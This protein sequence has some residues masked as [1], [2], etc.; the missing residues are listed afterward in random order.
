[1]QID[2]G[3]SCEGVVLGGLLVH[4]H[5]DLRVQDVTDV[6]LGAGADVKPGRQ[7]L[8]VRGKHVLAATRNPHRVQGAQDDEVGGLAP[9]AVDGP[10]PDR[11]IV[12]CGSERRLPGACRGFFDHGKAGW[13]DVPRTEGGRAPHPTRLTQITPAR[14][15]H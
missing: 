6:S 14:S 10:D 11:Q 2:P 4:A 5:E 15:R 9:R 7:A 3:L 1:M 12:D 13:H 8:D